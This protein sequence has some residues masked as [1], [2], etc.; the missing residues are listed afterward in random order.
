MFNTRKYVRMMKKQRLLKCRAEETIFFGMST[1]DGKY[2][3]K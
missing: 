3:A 1:K 2:Y